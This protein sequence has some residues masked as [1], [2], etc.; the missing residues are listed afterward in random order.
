MNVDVFPNPSK[1]KVPA[2][3][4]YKAVVK[5]AGKVTSAIYLGIGYGST[6]AAARR[7]AVADY[8]KKHK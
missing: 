5:P 2:R 1:Q 3:L 6:K 4:K 8:R 7:R